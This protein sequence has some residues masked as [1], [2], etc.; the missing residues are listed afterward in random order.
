MREKYPEVA[1]G[2]VGLATFYRCL[3]DALDN[4][5]GTERRRESEGKANKEPSKKEME[6]Y[7]FEV[8]VKPETKEKK[9]MVDVISSF[10]RRN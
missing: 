3:D 5:Y 9:P 6:D 7:T 1:E 4:R 10:F 2:S 8:E